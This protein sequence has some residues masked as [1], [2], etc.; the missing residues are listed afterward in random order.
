VRFRADLVNSEDGRRLGEIR[1]PF[2]VDER[3]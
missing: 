3:S 1:I 2:N